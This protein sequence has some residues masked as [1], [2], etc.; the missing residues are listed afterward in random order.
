MLGKN[1]KWGVQEVVT[2]PSY[3]IVWYP[4]LLL[5]MQA[6]QMFIQCTLARIP[7]LQSI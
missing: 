7:C 4:V 1:F 6:S 2:P 5:G 3:N